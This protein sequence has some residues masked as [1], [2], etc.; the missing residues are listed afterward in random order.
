LSWLSVPVVASMQAPRIHKEAILPHPYTAQQD[1]FPLSTRKP[2]KKC[3]FSSAH[4]GTGPADNAESELAT[5]LAAFRLA[6]PPSKELAALSTQLKEVNARLWD[7]KSAIGE[8]E[9]TGSFGPRFIELARSAYSLGDAR[10]QLKAKI[11]E[12]LNHP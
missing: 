9:Q 12:L 4:P 6:Y 1:R 2:P 3:L 8:C 7:T 11:N 5:L 10:A